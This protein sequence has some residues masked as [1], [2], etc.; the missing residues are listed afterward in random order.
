MAQ[1]ENPFFEQ[2]SGS[3]KQSD[4]SKKLSNDSHAVSKR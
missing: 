2:Q 1:N 3:L 4:E